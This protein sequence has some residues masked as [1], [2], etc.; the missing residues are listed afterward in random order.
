MCIDYIF[1][2]MDFKFMLYSRERGL[3]I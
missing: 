2:R 1:E 3:I